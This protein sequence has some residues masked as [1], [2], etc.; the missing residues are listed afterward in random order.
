[1]GK[2]RKGREIVLQA[3]YAARISGRPL[4]ACL[5]DQLERRGPHDE[6]ARFARA[7]AEKLGAHRG[8]AEAWLARLVENWDPERLGLVERI[9]LLI[10]LTELRHSPDVPWRVVINEACELAR[11]FG[12]EQAVGFVNGVLDRAAAEVLRRDG[13]RPPGE[14][15][16]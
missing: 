4:A 16:A 2:R 7:L 3:A 1:V 15:P 14:E 10:A 8:A 9:L 11:R 13:A 6:T 5:D 12:D